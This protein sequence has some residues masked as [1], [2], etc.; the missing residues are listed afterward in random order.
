MDKL[1]Y[2]RT[3]DT[4]DKEYEADIICNKRKMGT[5]T[6]IQVKIVCKN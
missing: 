2:K 5:K 3:K 4:Y 6:L 1:I